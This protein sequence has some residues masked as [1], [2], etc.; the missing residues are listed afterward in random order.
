MTMIHERTKCATD[1]FSEI[2]EDVDSL[3]CGGPFNFYLMLPDTT[4]ICHKDSKDVINYALF[5]GQP[6][7]MK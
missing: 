2:G 5:N 4:K 1:R 7:E 3:A 6:N